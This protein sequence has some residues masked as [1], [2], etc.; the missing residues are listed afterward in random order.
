MP[1]IL[2]KSVKKFLLVTFASVILSLSS[3]A[4][5]ACIDYIG[6]MSDGTPVFI[7][8]GSSFGNYAFYND[9]ELGFVTEQASDINEYCNS[10]GSCFTGCLGGI[11]GVARLTRTRLRA[12]VASKYESRLPVGRID[13]ARRSH[14]AGRQP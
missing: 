7:S 2:K 14:V 1:S 12:K 8:C 4:V 6:N 9:S 10:C 11:A 13:P 5:Y 3:S